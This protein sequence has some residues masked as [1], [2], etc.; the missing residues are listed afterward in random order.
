MN[1][2]LIIGRFQPFH[3]G[4]LSLI[5]KSLS[6]ADEIIIAIGSSNNKREDINPFLTE[7]RYTMIEKV[8]IAENLPKKKIHIVDIQNEESDTLW[9]ENIQKTCPSF[10]SVYTGTNTGY[11]Y[12]KKLFTS[13]Q[14]PFHII[15]NIIEIDA[16]TLREKMKNNDLSWKQMLH[17]STVQYLHTINGIQIV[18]SAIK[19]AP[20]KT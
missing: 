10:D 17:A 12:M 15:K 4:H 18:Q 2:I 7:E 16:S 5:K 14:K 11:E 20:K 8:I 19:T 13:V 6:D 1:R 9:L 3:L